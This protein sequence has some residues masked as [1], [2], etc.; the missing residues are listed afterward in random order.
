MDTKQKRENFV[1]LAEART[2]KALALID[3]IGNLSNS[4]SYEYT[5]DEVNRIFTS[6][7]EA[8]KDNRAKFNKAKNKKRK[9]VL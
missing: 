9:F 4:S 3:L 8:I 6:L 7:S 1:R 5:E 2:N